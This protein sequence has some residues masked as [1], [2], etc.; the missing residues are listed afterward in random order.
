MSTLHLF[1]IGIEFDMSGTEKW[2]AKSKPKY[3][4]EDRNVGY[5][6]TLLDKAFILEF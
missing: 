5:E 3:T 1:K 6:V 4:N 2:D